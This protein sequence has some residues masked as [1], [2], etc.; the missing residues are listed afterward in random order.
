MY[1]P[2]PHE[3]RFRAIIQNMREAGHKL[4]IED[5]EYILKQF[6]AIGYHYGSLRVLREM[7]FIGMRP[8]SKS[9]GLTFQALCHRLTLP[10]QRKFRRKQI[11]EAVTICNELITRMRASE[12]P[13]TQATTDLIYRI[14]NKTMAVDT[15]QTFL[16]IVYG[17]DLSYP[18]RPPLEF[19]RGDKDQDSTPALSPMSPLP[20]STSALNTTIEVL[21]KLRNMSKLVQAFEVLTTRLPS[22][23][24][25][26]PASSFEDD[27]DDDFGINRPAVAHFPLP[28]ARP[29]TFTYESLLRGISRTSSHHLARH[30]M[31]QALALDMDVTRQLRD[32]VIRYPPEAI[33]APTFAVTR[34]MLLSVF[35]LANRMKKIELIKWTLF[36]AR[37]VLRRKTEDIAY[38]THI[39]VQWQDARIRRVEVEALPRNSDHDED[40]PADA[41][42]DPSSSTPRVSVVI[43]PTS[44]SHR[45]AEQA[46]RSKLPQEQSMPH[47]AVDLDSQALPSEPSPR[48]FDIDTHLAAL[49][50]QRLKL[51]VFVRHV[52]DALGRSTQ[53]VKE[54]L[55]RRVWM[56]KSVYLRHTGRCQRLHPTTWVSKVNFKTT[57]ALEKST[58]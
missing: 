32:D 44:S 57:M 49:Q 47:F 6:A 20:F 58:S 46:K 34:R 3:A 35:S 7:S 33:H 27:D 19:W 10:A 54:R 39:Q 4:D 14:L 16:K 5:Y 38:Y 50:T 31:L 13:F 26:A 41:M 53:R 24:A 48:K 25:V 37:R 51:A 30:Y 9:Y 1:A 52:E 42:A 17:V 12:V 15:L 43:T 22:Q 11:T 29:N 21:G 8:T 28:Y 2:H 23:S 18:D 45:L 56:G 55:G 40:A 36:K